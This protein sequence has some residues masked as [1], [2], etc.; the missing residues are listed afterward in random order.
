MTIIGWVQF[1]VLIVA[2]GL[3]ITLSIVVLLKS[4]REGFTRKRTATF[5]LALGLLFIVYLAYN[6]QEI[7]PAD[8]VQIMLVIGLVAVTG[9]YAL[10]TARQADASE[11]MAEEM[12]QQRLDEVR[13]YLLLKLQDGSFSWDTESNMP[14]DGKFTVTIFNAGKGP[15][16]GLVAAFWYPDKVSFLSIKG[17][18]VSGRE[19]K[20]VI[21]GLPVLGFGLVTG[22]KTWLPELSKLVKH[23]E[24]GV[25]AVEYKDVHM[26]RKWV[27]YLCLER[28]VNDAS[29]AIEGEQNIV[30]LKNND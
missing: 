15:A 14:V 2:I 21:I 8:M 7:H 12:R 13:P 16:T 9:V 26:K 17:Y 11:K 27:S 10:F 30:E 19:W 29:V 24:L 1:S 3:S 5:V 18:L 4:I 6:A 28:L 25:V 20:T 22:K 23:P